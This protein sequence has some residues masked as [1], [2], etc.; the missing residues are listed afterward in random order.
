MADPELEEPSLFS[1]VEAGNLEQLDQRLAEEEGRQ[2]NLSSLN[3]EG[4]T[5]LEFA[6]MLG[7]GEVARLLVNKGADINGSNKSGKVCCECYCH[8]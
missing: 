8:R 3:S 2:M 5:P 4:R 7:K 6:V 1:L